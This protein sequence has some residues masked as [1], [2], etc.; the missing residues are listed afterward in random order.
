MRQKGYRLRYL[1]F[2]FSRRTCCN[3]MPYANTISHLYLVLK[4]ISRQAAIEG[5]AREKLRSKVTSTSKSIWLRLRK[6]LPRWPRGEARWRTER[7]SNGYRTGTEPNSRR[8][9]LVGVIVKGRSDG[10][11]GVG[12]VTCYDVRGR[13]PNRE[14]T[15]RFSIILLPTGPDGVVHVTQTDRSRE[16]S[17]VLLVGDNEEILIWFKSFRAN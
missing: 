2:H 8:H 1:L 4:H 7:V 14:V 15:V 10:R 12:G 16:T 17:K 6:K 5:F 13:L 9:H 3:K 11:A